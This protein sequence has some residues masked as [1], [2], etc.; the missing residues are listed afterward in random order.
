MLAL[1]AQAA[2]NRN[3]NANEP[4]SEAFWVII[5]ITVAFVVIVFVLHILFLLTLSKTLSRC[6]PR[7]RTMEPGQVW[8]NL[9]PFFNIVWQFITVTRLA[10]S[11]KHEFRYRG[12]STRDNDFGQSLGIVACVL[13]LLGSCFSLAGLICGIVYWTK[14]AEFN[15]QLATKESDYYEDDEDDYEDDDEDEDERKNRD[16]ERR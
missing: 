10:E 15:N 4:P 11:L 13:I 2:G 7:N 3:N 8:L 16:W 14:I 12:W 9:I 1:F 6:R 5:G